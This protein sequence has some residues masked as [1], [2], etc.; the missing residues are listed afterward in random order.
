MLVF[1]VDYMP[2]VE[3]LEALFDDIDE[4]SYGGNA[5]P[6]SSMDAQVYTS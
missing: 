2:E 6:D 5:A 1:Y 4:V 3:E